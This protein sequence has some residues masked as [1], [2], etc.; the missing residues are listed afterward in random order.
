MR[1]RPCPVITSLVLGA[2]ALTAFGQGAGSVA[3]E[4]AKVGSSAGGS[5]QAGVSLVAVSEDFASASAIAK[6]RVGAGTWIVADGVLKGVEK[7]ENK[8]VA[9]LACPL[10]YHD[11]EIRFRVQF[12]GGSVAMLLLRN[13]LGNLCRVTMTRNSITLTKD[14]PNLPRDNTEKTVVLAKCAAAF[15]AG[16]WYDVRVSVRGGEFCAT[17]GDYPMLRGDH[18]GIDLDKTEVEFLAGGN[19]ILFDDLIVAKLG[20]P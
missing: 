18:V 1:R 10:R 14:R 11:A 13:Q 17:V 12:N 15:D 20:R 2:L 9:G 7:A 6:W 5:T 8:H 19:S 16:R 3:G 4:G